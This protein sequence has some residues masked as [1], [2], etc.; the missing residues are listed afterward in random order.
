MLAPRHFVPDRRLVDVRLERGSGRTFRIELQ[1]L[2]HLIDGLGE[3]ALLEKAV[4][5]GIARARQAFNGRTIFRA[6]VYAAEP[7]DQ[8]GALLIQSRGRRVI[9]L[10]LQ[11]LR[12]GQCLFEHYDRLLPAQRL[13]FRRLDR[14]DLRQQRAA[15]DNQAEETKNE[16]RKPQKWV[17]ASYG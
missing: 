15:G 3:F 5:K 4:R 1:Q 7:I 14:V 17:G 6:D 2:V 10:I 8:S 12:V 13:F 11:T 9:P 16:R